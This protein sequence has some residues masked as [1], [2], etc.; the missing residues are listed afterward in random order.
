MLECLLR[1][2]D[3]AC[4]SDFAEMAKNHCKMTKVISSWWSQV[5]GVEIP[6]KWHMSSKDTH[7]F[8]SSPNYLDKDSTIGPAAKRIPCT[9]CKTQ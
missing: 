6:A 3:V 4:T 7:T 2:Q 8:Q 1:G 9:E 5:S